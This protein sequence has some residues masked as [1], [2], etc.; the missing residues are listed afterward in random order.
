M[1]RIPELE[2]LAELSDLLMNDLPKYLLQMEEESEESIRLLPLRYAGVE[3]GLKTP[4]N[5]PYAILE[6]EEA[7]Q[8]E[9]DRI[10]KQR[11]Y[12]ITVKLR[13]VEGNAVFYYFTGLRNSILPLRKYRVFQEMKK[14]AKICFEMKAQN[15]F[16]N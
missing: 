11:V 2:I 10:I 6:I 9:K 13:K 4:P 14:E 16:V 7:E 5:G 12:G 15:T 1:K 8:M 3:E